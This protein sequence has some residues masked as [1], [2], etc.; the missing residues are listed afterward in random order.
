MGGWR[1]AA[2]G[3]A[4]AAT[5]LA[6]A[7]CTALAGSARIQNYSGPA[8]P[9]FTGLLQPAGAD[10]K[11]RFIFQIH[12][13]KTPDPDWGE[14]LLKHIPDYGYE[15]R[16]K[17][18]LW[19]PA[20]LSASKVLNGHPAP[21]GDDNPTCVF[22]HFG[23]YKKDVFVNGS[24]GE[25]VVVYTY[26]WRGDL[27]TITGPYLEADIK[28]NETHGLSSRK[29]VINAAIKSALLDNGLSDAAGYV[30]DVGDMEREGIETAICAMYAD[31]IATQAARDIVTSAPGTGCL[32]KLY[33]LHTV[34]FDKVEFNFLSHSLGSRMLYDVLSADLPKGGGARSSAAIEAR[35]VLADR[36]RTFFMAANQLPLLAVAGMS[37]V[38]GAPPAHVSTAAARN[39][40]A[41]ALTATP[42]AFFNLRS[43]GPD[44]AHPKSAPT[45]ELSVVAFQDPDDILGYKASDG[46]LP[47]PERRLKFVDVLHRNTNQYLF[48]LASP[49]EAHDN[50]LN[51][52]HSLKMILCGAATDTAGRLSPAACAHA[53]P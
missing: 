30:S 4:L 51:E 35:R 8:G 48:L 41:L 37:V 2:R 13:I 44:R 3:L 47:D 31:A 33:D 1:R 50:E 25:E 19:V 46:V 40:N 49:V 15:R 43:V 23:Q 32:A 29:S 26:F 52:P 27:W 6:M 38:P 28:D 36:T 17:T 39:P 7:G 11:R 45:Q 5:G 18:D 20:R 16:T 14:S 21:C 9:A 53:S 24:A 10:V 34:F 12:G 22:D 42:N